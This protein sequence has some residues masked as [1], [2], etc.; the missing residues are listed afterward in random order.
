MISVSHLDLP[1]QHLI[2]FEL[3]IQTNKIG[4]NE[5]ISMGDQK[6]SIYD[7]DNVKINKDFRFP[8]SKR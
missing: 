4:T 6:S 1:R 7:A 8:L 5:I 3:L 2:F